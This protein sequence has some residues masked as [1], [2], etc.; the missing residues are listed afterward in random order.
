MSSDGEDLAACASGDEKPSA[1]E[2]LLNSHAQSDDNS[3]PEDGLKGRGKGKG[4]SKGVKKTAN[5]KKK[6]SQSGR[7]VKNLSKAGFKTCTDCG[8]DKALSEFKV[9]NAVCT[10][11]CVRTK[12]NIYRA[13]KLEGCLEWPE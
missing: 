8:D 2:N 7:G 6:G 1:G 10:Y 3:E 12:D 13:C 4:R 5:K 11:P 9:G